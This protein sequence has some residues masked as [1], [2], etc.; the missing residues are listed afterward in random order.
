MKFQLGVRL[1]CM[2]LFA[3]MVLLVWAVWH[4]MLF[5]I[6]MAFC[7][8]AWAANGQWE[9]SLYHELSWNPLPLKLMSDIRKSR[10]QFQTQSETATL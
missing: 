1:M 8:P 2:L 10:S 5:V 4:V 3:P 7:I 6:A 9:G